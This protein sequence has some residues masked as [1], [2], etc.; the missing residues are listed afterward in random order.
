MLGSRK[1]ASGQQESKVLEVHVNPGW[2]PGTKLRY[3]A[4][5]NGELFL[6]L[7]DIE[8]NNIFAFAEQNVNGRIKTQDFVF[9]VEEKPHDR[10]T[11]DGDNLIYTLKVPLSEALSGPV[12]AA[13]SKKSL[14]TLDKRIIQ[15]SVPYPN[16]TTGGVTLKPDQLITVKGEGF[17]K[18]GGAK[19]DLQVKI[20]V[21][22][23][24]RLNGDQASRIRAALS[25][26]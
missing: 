15:Y 8:P 26:N 17:P 22:F 18:K 11:R 4:A 9:V 7:K 21:V 2:K 20:E 10:F 25:G 23:P 19:G 3:K 1:L 24:D 12:N 6:P 5:G 14:T 16:P 13:S